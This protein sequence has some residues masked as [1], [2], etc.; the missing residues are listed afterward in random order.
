MIDI[1]DIGGAQRRRYPVS[2]TPITDGWKQVTA[3]VVLY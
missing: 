1:V 3:L 2:F